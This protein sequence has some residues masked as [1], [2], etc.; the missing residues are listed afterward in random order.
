MRKPTGTRLRPQSVPQFS[1]VAR[2]RRIEKVGFAE[3]PIANTGSNTTGLHVHF[4]EQTSEEIS[5][6]FSADAT[7]ELE[8]GPDP[9]SNHGTAGVGSAAVRGRLN[10]HAQPARTLTNSDKRMILAR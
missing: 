4:G 3:L 7:D 1:D 8:R 9:A 6:R 2:I 10:T 5:R